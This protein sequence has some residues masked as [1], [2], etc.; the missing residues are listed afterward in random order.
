[1]LNSLQD[2]PLLHWWIFFNYFILFYSKQAEKLRS[3]VMRL[4]MKIV[5]KMVMNIMMKVVTKVE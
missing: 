2:Q 1:M 5:M 4:V 3:L